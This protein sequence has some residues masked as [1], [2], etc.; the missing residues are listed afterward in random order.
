MKKIFL[1]LGLAA[2]FVSFNQLN[3]QNT[4]W[5]YNTD[6]TVTEKSTSEVDK[7]TFSDQMNNMLLYKDDATTTFDVSKINYITFSTLNMDDENGIYI[8]FNGD[9]ALVYTSIESESLTVEV[10]GADVTITSKMKVA[11][12]NY[13]VYG[14]STDG[15][16]T[17]KN[18]KDFN[19]ILNGLSLT[20]QTAVPVKSSK[21]V[22][23]NIIIANGTYNEISDTENNA[24]KPVISTSWTTNISGNG[25]LVVNSNKKNGISCDA[26]INI[27]SGNITVNVNGDA[28]KGIKADSTITISGGTITCNP[29]GNVTLEEVGSGYDPSYCAGIS[30]DQ[31]IIV[32]GGT[33]T[34]TISEKAV[35]GRGIKA[36]GSITFYGGSV[37]ITSNGGGAT[38]KDS[39][40]TTDSYKSSCIKADGDIHFKGGT[41]NLTANGNAGKCV[42]ADGQITFGY[43]ENDVVTED[44]DGE[45]PYF[46]AVTTG[47]HI[48][49]SAAQG[50]G[51]DADYANPKA[52]K[53]MGNLYVNH[54]TLNITTKNDGGEGLES[55]D[56]LFINGGVIEINTYDD[57][58]NAKNY[59]QVN[60]GK[61]FARST[62][63]DGIDCNGSMEFT[64]G[65]TIAIGITSPEEG[66]DCDNNPFKITGGTL[67]GIGGS[68]STP[69]SS[70]CTQNSLIY[71]SLENS[72]A[73]RIEDS[74]GNELVTFQVPTISGQQ[75][76]GQGGGGWWKSTTAT[77]GPGGGRGGNG[78]TL[79]FS[80]PDL[81]NGTYTIKQGGT[82]SGGT[83]WNGY[84]TGAGYD[85]ATTTKSVSVSSKVTTAN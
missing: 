38:Y 62:G 69:T 50:W 9:T 18:D 41:F 77:K 45:A 80:S 55:K 56:T 70:L 67:I 20:S 36:D 71:Q 82:I 1:L 13:Y 43:G 34:M 5:I 19:L 2:C 64:G 75:G 83:E 42:T 35:A 29:N 68:T 46:T 66:F 84:Y 53:A 31:D 22:T 60:G 8:H 78:L 26:D 24:K 44:Y 48:L 23:C 21:E 73:L 85:G 51:Q 32:S 59:I 72:T 17:I 27:T 47:E 15:S 76:G 58:I 57:A 14:S 39:T 30:S 79:L 16:L 49:E 11:D 10:D 40:G 63:N 3:A 74:E 7:I 61:T 25:T 6:G 28:G 4:M 37:E 54:G 52:V 65:L 33:I 81:V 12:L